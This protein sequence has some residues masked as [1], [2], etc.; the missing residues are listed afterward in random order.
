M[1]M[2]TVAMGQRGKLVI[3]KD[4]R[5]DL[6][7]KDG[8]ELVLFENGKEILIR[9]Q[10]KVSQ[11]LEDADF[12]HAA[13]EKTL[14]KIWEKEPDGLWEAYLS[15]NGKEKLEALKKKVKK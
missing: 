9:K 15:A 6:S 5:E 7:I 10:E 11:A 1:K 13:Q 14:E 3:P 4:F 2:K 12:W 8:E